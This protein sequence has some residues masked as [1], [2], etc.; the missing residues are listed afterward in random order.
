MVQPVNYKE[1]ISCGGTKYYV[2]SGYKRCDK[3]RGRVEDLGHRCE[4]IGNRQTHTQK[5]LREML[6]YGPEPEMVKGK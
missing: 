3:C 4:R 6:G 1:C 5:E 2:S